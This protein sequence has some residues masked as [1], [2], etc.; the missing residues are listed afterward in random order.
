ML[1]LIDGDT[2][3]KNHAVESGCRAQRPATF[4]VK[5]SAGQASRETPGALGEKPMQG[6]MP[7]C[8][9]DIIGTLTTC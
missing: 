9:S 7:L 3:N 6:A 4:G 2:E 5:G 8:G 1:R